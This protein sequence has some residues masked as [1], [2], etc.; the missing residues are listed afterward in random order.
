VKTARRREPLA[1][2]VV[3]SGCSRDK[4]GHCDVR[5]RLLLVDPL[6]KEY[7]EPNDSKVWVGKPP[8]AAGTSRL[9]AG[10]MMIEIEPGDPPGRYRVKA[11]VIDRVAGTSLDREWSFE[12]AP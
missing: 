10:Y 7:G 11:H 3:L 9:G 12:V 6:Q 4:Q 5:A 1:A 2:F 8:P